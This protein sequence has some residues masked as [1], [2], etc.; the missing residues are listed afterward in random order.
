[1]LV[2]EVGAEC[3]HVVQKARLYAEVSLVGLFPLRVLVR[4]GVLIDD[5]AARA[6]VAHVQPAAACI[7]ASHQSVGIAEL[8]QA[9]PRRV[10]LDEGLLG[11][12]PAYG[13]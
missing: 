7:V 9:Q 11:C 13:G 2:E 5:V 3:E 1:V 12:H 8:Q 4:D 10:L 6:V